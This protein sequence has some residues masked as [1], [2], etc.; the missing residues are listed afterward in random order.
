MD[1][2]MQ[3]NIFQLSTSYLLSARRASEL[4]QVLQTFVRDASEKKD[5]WFFKVFMK[6]TNLI[7]FL[8]FSFCELAR[9]LQFLSEAKS[10]NHK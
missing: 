3:E 2:A 10:K 4:T 6:I 7:F 9:I 1:D 5:F 8:F